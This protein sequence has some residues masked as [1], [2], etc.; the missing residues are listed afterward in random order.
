MGPVL[1]TP[2]FAVGCGRLQLV[3]EQRTCTPRYV[4]SFERVLSA[5]RA[6]NKKA[7]AEGTRQV[8]YHLRSPSPRVS[9]E[10]Q[11]AS[12]RYIKTRSELD[13]IRAA[14]QA[15]HER[16]RNVLANLVSDARFLERMKFE[17][18]GCD[19]LDPAD[20]QNLAEQTA[21]KG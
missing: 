15:T 5:G 14:L 19:P 8:T 7:P 4:A 17:R 16:A 18:L 10:A 1:Q 6:M 2:V 3:P 13:E 9:R 12:P 20:A 21:R 11:M